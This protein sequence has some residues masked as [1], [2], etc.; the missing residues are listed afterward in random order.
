MKFKKGVNMKNKD[1]MKVLIDRVPELH[2]IVREQHFS[3]GNYVSYR[4][5]ED[6][7]WVN[8][9]PDGRIVPCRLNTETNEYEEIEE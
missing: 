9:Y 6:G 7:V 5:K 4:R 8:E 1:P 2:K 3:K